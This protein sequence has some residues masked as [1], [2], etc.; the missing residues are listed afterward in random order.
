MTIVNA[1]VGLQQ[2]VL[3]EYRVPFFN[4]LGQS[5]SSGL[6]VFAGLPRTREAI[7]TANQLTDAQLVY[8]RNMHLFS[9]RTYFCIQNGFIRWLEHFQPEVLIVE[10]NPRYLSTPAAIQWMHRRH[11]PVIGWGLGAPKAGA[12]E[13][14]LRTRFLK[15]LDAVIAYS[16]T[17]AGQ[18]IDVGI[19]PE[20]VFVAPNA[21]S[22]RPVASPP[23][24]SMEFTNGKPSLLFIGR[25]QERK[26]LDL[27]LEACGALPASIQPEL[28]I[29][30]D[31]PDRFRLEEL[32]SIHYPSARFEGAKHGVELERYFAAADLFVL[33]GTG[34]LAVQQAMAHAL[35]VMVGEADGTQAELVRPENGWLLPHSSVDTLVE[36]LKEALSNV[37]RL[38][39]M[40][41]ASYKIVSKEVNLENMVHAFVDTINYVLKS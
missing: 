34:G 41:A 38:R 13:T 1:R 15:S 32:A 22:P 31:G 10:A 19:A 11:R 5:C 20:Q 40:G 27:L 17:G 39:Q 21:V 25:L 14:R 33:P 37:T 26:R 7:S 16:Q 4:A 9:G 3:P 24:R 8:A 12:A 18:Y 23:I 2:R 30:G 6:Q 29:I 36:H 35:P 28:V